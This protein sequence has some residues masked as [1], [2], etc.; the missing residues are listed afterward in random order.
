MT[1]EEFKQIMLRFLN[2]P[3][4]WGGDDPLDGFDCS[5]LVQE[6][7]AIL[8]MD[9]RGDQTAHELFTYFLANGVKTDFLNLDTGYLLF[10]GQDSKITHIAL[11]YDADTMM[12]AGGGGPTTLSYLE[13][14][15]QN[16]YVRLRPIFSRKDLVQVIRPIGLPWI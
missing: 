13:A 9:P 3:Y 2:I 11:C 10:F 8:G 15:K 1:R 5:G 16:A 12:E 4:R 6:L 14:T 7:L